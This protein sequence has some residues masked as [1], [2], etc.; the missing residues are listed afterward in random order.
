MNT[1]SLRKAALSDFD[2]LLKFKRDIQSMHV[3]HTRNFYKDAQN[4]LTYEEL[5]EV[6]TEKDGRAAYVLVQDGRLIA[7]AFTKILEIKGNP[8]IYDHRILFIEDMYVEA[9]SR[10]K[11]YGHRLM[12]ELKQIASEKG[13]RTITLEVWEWNKDAIAFYK[14]LGLESTQVRMKLWIPESEE[15]EKR[16]TS[17]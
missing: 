4:P 1:P 6:V 2:Q 14:S 17:R 12:N 10:R 13:C 16:L 9:Q 3:E 15:Q 5:S 7:Y 11:G 8:L